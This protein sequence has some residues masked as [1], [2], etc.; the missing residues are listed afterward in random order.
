MISEQTLIMNMVGAIF[1]SGG[2]WAF[3]TYIIQRR[4]N[5]D[6]AETQML[7]GLGHDRICHLGSEYIK[8]GCI[9]K[10]DY[11]NLHDYLFI[12]YKKLGGN[13][14]AEK[15]MKEIDKLPL[16]TLEDRA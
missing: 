4:D 16:C 3:L 5:K 2:F 11:E 12:P 15:I 13:G 8:E 9:S 7:K 10:D 6:S 14:T 1:A